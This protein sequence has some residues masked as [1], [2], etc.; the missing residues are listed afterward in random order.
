MSKST[1]SF[2]YNFASFAIFY[3]ASKYL[4]DAYSNLTGIWLGLTAFLIATILSPK[5]QMVKTKEGQKLFMKIV[6]V[7][8][9]KEIS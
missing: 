9:V 2:I 4:L 6:F 7:K 1:K 5:F 8:G 3:F